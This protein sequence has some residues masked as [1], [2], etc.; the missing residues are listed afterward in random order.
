MA[1]IPP[2]SEGVKLTLDILKIAS[3]ISVGLVTQKMAPKSPA[4]QGNKV[5]LRYTEGKKFLN[6]IGKGLEW[7]AN[8]S[9]VSG[10]NGENVEEE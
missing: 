10:K 7:L 1:P 9:Q 4:E 8:L 3:P 6:W 5:N 2:Q